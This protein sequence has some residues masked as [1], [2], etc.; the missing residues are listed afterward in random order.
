ML[1]L[2]SETQ[3]QS[4]G[5][6][7]R[8]AVENNPRGRADQANM[9]VAASRLDE[10]RRRFAPQVDLFGDLG[11]QDRVSP[12]ASTVSGDEGVLFTREIGVRASLVIFDGFERAN[13]VYRNAAMLDGATYR[14]LNTSE[15]LALNAVEAYVDVVR[16]RHLMEA[17][18]VNIARHREVL[19][20]VR[21]QVS[22]GNAPES[23]RLQIEE[24]VFA[25][26]IVAV[27][28][29]KAAED[30]NSKFQ[31]VIGSKPTGVMRVPRVKRIPHSRGNLVSQAVASNYSIK[32]AEKA[33]SEFGYAKE[34]AK[35][36][37]MPLLSLDGRAVAGE[38]RNGTT[39]DETDLFVG[40]TL[41]WRL[42]DGGVIKAR[43]RTEAQ[44]GLEAEFRRDTAIND[45]TNLAN[46]AWNAFEGSRKRNAMLLS[47]VKANKRIVDSFREEYTLSK[48]T[49][50][51]LL[52]AE[53]AHF[54]ARFQQISSAATLR[55]AGY[56]ML[57]AMSRLTDHFGINAHDIAPTP[58]YEERVTASPSSIFNITID[59]LQ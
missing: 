13:T 50:I 18:R 29:E 21:E 16:H 38:D 56:R 35:A 24:R 22:G 40:L 25:A 52:D 37:T 49:L 51:D 58:D 30:A 47:Q 12:T 32:Q 15:T 2:I 44:R 3:A 53:R 5:E 27:E 46:R 17:A 14:L 34:V 26:E 36:G 54:N 1:S 7:V 9:R 39:G 41:S 42:Y 19:N 11:K 31:Q 57:A 28:V 43:E 4:L 23:D 20:Q 55:F 45:V 10:S 33:I 8:M 6:A 59:P 48:R